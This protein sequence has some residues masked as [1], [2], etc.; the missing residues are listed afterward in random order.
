MSDYPR[1]AVRALPEPFPPDRI[2][3]ALFAALALLST[4]H[5][6]LY[7]LNRPHQAEDTAAWASWFGVYLVGLL[8]HLWILGGM[9]RSRFWAFM[10]TFVWLSLAFAGALSRGHFSV[11][12]VIWALVA[13]FAL[14]RLCGVVGPRPI[15]RRDI[16]R[17]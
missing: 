5:S 12:V 9:A 2:A 11:S 17:S 4:A 1:P 3:T 8:L 6:V 10:T 13:L 15:W 14:A 16:L 7:T